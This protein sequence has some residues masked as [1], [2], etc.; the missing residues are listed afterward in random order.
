M[1]K[2][3]TPEGEGFTFSFEGRTIAARPGETVAA[4]LLVAGVSATRTTAVGG[5]ARGPFCMMG[6]CFDCIAEVDGVGGVQTCMTQAR[7]GMV[8][9]RQVGVREMEA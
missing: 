3:I 9:V 2:R 4:A 1:F 8:V 6:A 7:P 5:A